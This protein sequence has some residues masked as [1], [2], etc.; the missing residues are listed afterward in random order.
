MIPDKGS[1]IP[2]PVVTALSQGKKIEAIKLLRNGTGIG[3]KEAKDMVEEYI[4]S[5]P[6]LSM[7]LTAEQEEGRKNLFRWVTIVAVLLLAAYWLFIRE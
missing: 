1:D 2:A 4:N 7:R 3:L 6:E 5:R